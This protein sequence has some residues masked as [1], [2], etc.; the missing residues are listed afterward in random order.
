MRHLLLCKLPDL[1]LPFSDHVPDLASPF[2]DRQPGFLASESEEMSFHY[3]AK[4]FVTKNLKSKSEQEAR[5]RL[6]KQRWDFFNQSLMAEHHKKRNRGLFSWCVQKVYLYRTT[7]RGTF[8]GRGLHAFLGLGKPLSAT[9]M[10]APRRRP[11][12]ATPGGFTTIADGATAT[13]PGVAD[14]SLRSVLDASPH[15]TSLPAKPPLCRTESGGPHAPL[16][17]CSK[18]N[19]NTPCCVD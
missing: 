8:R 9:A 4:E 15:S 1:A 3:N 19:A 14:T 2:E 6:K 10:R 5:Y 7:F 12:S 18:W 13:P 11:S 16:S 17:T